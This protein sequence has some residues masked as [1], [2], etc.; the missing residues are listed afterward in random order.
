[1]RVKA[2]LPDFLIFVKTRHR[3]ENDT[4]INLSAS[5]CKTFPPFSRQRLL[6]YLVGGQI[7]RTG[8]DSSLS[9]ATCS[10]ASVAPREGAPPH[11]EQITSRFLIF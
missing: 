3:R 9:D 2:R 7:D 6:M 4:R 8:W 11:S 1:M 5:L 10:G